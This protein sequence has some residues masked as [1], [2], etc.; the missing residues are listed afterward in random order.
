VSD[1]TDTLRWHTPAGWADAVLDDDLALL[2]DH[3]H[4]EQAAASNALALVRRWP[5]GA[6]PARWVS[7]LSGVA[8]DEV[9]H[10][11][12][13]SRILADRGGR[14]PRTHR[15]PYAAALRARADD[16]GS[17]ALVDRLYVSALIELRSHERFLLLAASDHD[18]A[19]LYADLEASEA[20][21]HRLFVQLAELAGGSDDRWSWW[22]EI[23]AEVAAAQPPGPWMHSGAPYA[24]G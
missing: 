12:R 14:L 15:N 9:D 6:D 22:L 4:L 3:A 17:R 8:R 23:E 11:A 21:H 18:L 1:R 2:A 16:S 5:D 13:V 24:A 10:L 20:G 7:W 19:G